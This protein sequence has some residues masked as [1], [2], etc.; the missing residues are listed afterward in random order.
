LSFRNA[1]MNIYAK[2]A[3]YHRADRSKMLLE[4]YLKAASDWII[5][6]EELRKVELKKLQID[7]FIS[8][9]LSSNDKT[10]RP[11]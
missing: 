8:L 7:E 6:D 3:N 9:L 2:E 10:S 1:L 11:T 4:D 5:S